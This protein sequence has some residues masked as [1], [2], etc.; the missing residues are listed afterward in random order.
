[1][2]ILLFG[3]LMLSTGISYGQKKV[4]Y[5]IELGSLI[6]T[7]SENAVSL[8]YAMEINQATGYSNKIFENKYRRKGDMG[9]GAV[10]DVNLKYPLQKRF[11]LLGGVGFTYLSNEITTTVI[12]SASEYSITDQGVHLVVG[13]NIDGYVPMDSNGNRIW[14]MSIDENGIPI[15]SSQ[16][17]LNDYSIQES[18]NTFYFLVPLNIGFEISKKTQVTFGILNSLLLYSYVDTKYPY[19]D[20]RIIKN[21]ISFVNKYVNYVQGGFSYKVGKRISLGFKYQRSLLD[22]IDLNKEYE[23]KKGS[24]IN[25]FSANLDY[26]IRFGKNKQ[27]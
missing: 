11:F 25:F 4:E 24:K 17:D 9:Y 22:L 21:N 26:A 27:L 15:A 20:D 3:I 13:K 10:M 14:T 1:M 2:R 19:S 16:N 18:F 7:L 12:S 23:V 5:H 6:S 8:D